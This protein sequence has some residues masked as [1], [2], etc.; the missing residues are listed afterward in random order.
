MINANNIFDVTGR[1]KQYVSGQKHLKKIEEAIFPSLGDRRCHIVLIKGS[2]GM[3]KTRLLEEAMRR[4][5]H[6]EMIKTYGAPTAQ[7]DWL[8]KHPGRV[9][10][11]NLFD[12]ID[13]RLH[14]SR[15]FKETLGDR[16]NWDD[17][18]VTFGGFE[19]AKLRARRYRQSG[20]GYNLLEEADKESEKAFW[21]DYKQ[22][23][24]TRR[25]V[26]PLDTVEQL[27]VLT[28][29]W[30]VEHDLLTPENRRDT[31]EQWLVENINAGNFQNST[32][33]MAGR[34]LEGEAFFKRFQQSLDEKMVVLHYVETT[35]L[36]VVEIADYFRALTKDWESSTKANKQLVVTTLQ[37]IL[38]DADKL[39]VFSMYTSG[40][41]VRL[42]IYTDLLIEGNTVPAPLN[43][44]PQKAEKRIEAY[45]LTQVRE[46][47]EQ[48]FVRL[49]FRR[50][51]LR[52]QI[53]QLLVRATRG[54]T[55]RQVHYILHSSP[56]DDP[57]AWDLEIERSEVKRKE[58]QD[59]E[60]EL[61]R[62][63]ELAIF[64]YKERV[65]SLAAH[66]DP[67]QSQ[68]PKEARYGLQDEIY[69]IY[70]RCVIGDITTEASERRALYEA[71]LRWVEPRLHKME[72]ERQ[73]FT[74]K[75]L[76]EIDIKSPEEIL[77]TRLPDM[78]LYEEQARD[79]VL[80]QLESLRLEY[81]HYKIILKPY[82]HFSLYLDLDFQD[83]KAGNSGVDS[84]LFSTEVSRTLY[85]DFVMAFVEIDVPDYEKFDTPLASLRRFFEQYQVARWIMILGAQQRYREAIELAERV[86]AEIGRMREQDSNQY[87]SWTR[88][89]IQYERLCWLYRAKIMAGDFDT[90]QLEPLVLK[91]EDIAQ[92][93]YKDEE[94]PNFTGDPRQVRMVFVLAQL[95]N[96]RG[97]AKTQRGL[98]ATGVKHYTKAEQYLR[99]Q[100]GLFMDEVAN[101]LNN[102]SRALAEMGQKRSIRICEDGLQIRVSKAILDPI[103]LSYNV[104][105]LG[106]NLLYRSEEALRSCA[107][108][109]AIARE[110]GNKRTLALVHIELAT[111]LRRTL[112]N[113]PVGRSNKRVEEVFRQ[114]DTA[115][116]RAYEHLSTNG[117]AN[118]HL[119]R[120]LI[121]WGCLYRDWHKMTPEMY[122]DMRQNF[123]RR[124][125]NYLQQAI[126]M[127]KELDDIR[128]KLDARINLAW[129]H[130][131]ANF[132]S[133]AEK[134]LASTEEVIKKNFP[135]AFFQVGVQPPQANDANGLPHYVFK[136]LAKIEDLRGRIA[137]DNYYNLTAKLE[138][139][140]MKSIRDEA[141]LAQSYSYLQEA[142][143]AYA[144]AS[145]YAEVFSNSSAELT[146]V[147]DSLYKYMKHFNSVEMR[148]YYEFDHDIRRN[149]RLKEI[150]LRDEGDTETFL[151][152]SFG[153]YYDDPTFG[154]LEIV[155]GENS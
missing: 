151:L 125:V 6:A 83:K 7:D 122:P 103:A 35:P 4:L 20:L 8:S 78:S 66:Q 99:S 2:G 67:M 70:H 123:Y 147:Y 44:T 84:T 43:D 17:P 96:L 133:D 94:L 61:G 116:G 111:A 27:A 89:W 58:L 37:Q 65:G 132:M 51:G 39:T 60:E 115:L 12:F 126:N 30:L 72:T 88:P 93:P 71:I 120:T 77:N 139:P 143:R 142:A 14:D 10:I 42:A 22:L 32:L 24:A 36:T 38:A 62:M 119:L 137:F 117:K 79:N 49:L 40:Q 26:I 19:A 90:S 135:H 121:E 69:R 152:D 134:E 57:T 130:Y 97:F 54:L 124:A 107:Q 153:N 45:G 138:A 16:L 52:A 1:P 41:P 18:E 109:Y 73:K 145:T 144:F 47:I 104:S 68:P 154:L 23:H 155:H 131:R 34:E 15:I 25:I 150:Q 80:R 148:L 141:L 146:R 53:L 114:A 106:Y 87:L 55:A 129:T 100:R 81:L 46:E 64:K 31:T 136:H 75:Q 91:L 5:R 11:S 101:I 112:R 13:I 127:G 29:N 118:I 102:K 9:I 74:Q 59:V 149:Y 33:L 63:T 95:Y 105:G 98:F 113:Y 48:E 86:E 28:S 128:L 21:E 85:E 56:H 140:P 76:A 50:P 108:A 3:G 92:H 82:K 110:V